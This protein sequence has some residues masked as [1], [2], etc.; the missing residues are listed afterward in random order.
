[1]TMIITMYLVG[2]IPTP[3]KQMKVSWDDYSQFMEKIMFQTTN[4]YDNH[5][6]RLQAILQ[7]ADGEALPPGIFPGTIKRFRI[8]SWWGFAIPSGNLT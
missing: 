4:Q 2:G 7:L 3:L 8:L 1:M 6:Y 5:Q